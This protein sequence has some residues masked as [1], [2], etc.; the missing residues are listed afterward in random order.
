LLRLMFRGRSLP[1]LRPGWRFEPRSLGF[2]GRLGL[3]TSV[4]IVV[5][6]VAQSWILAQRDLEHIRGYLTER[7]RTI[8]EYLAQEATVGIL[9]GNVHGLR[10]LAEQARAQSGVV[11]CRMFDREGLVLVSVG[12]PPTGSVP[13][14]AKVGATGPIAIGTDVW[15]FRV[16]IL[17]RDAQ[18]QAESP[19]L[20]TVAIGLSAASLRELR[21]RTMTTASIFTSLFTL[22]AVGAALLLARAI[23]RPLQALATAADAI[24]RGDFGAQVDVRTGD[25][26]GGL[27]R[28]FNA[29]AQSLAR[30]RTTLEEY[31]GALEEKVLE[32]ERANHLKSEFLAT[33]SH[34]LRTPLNVIIGYVEMLAES[35]GGSLS[36][37]QQE[38]LGAI[39]R[40]SRLQLDLI[41]DILDF[42]RLSSG[43][44]S[45][46]VERFEL[47]PLLT[48]IRALYAA[49]LAS[50][51]VQL[52]VVVAADLPPLESD[53]IKLQEIVRN[54]VDNAIKFTEEGVVSVTGQAGETSG[55]LRIEVADT[56]AGMPPEDLEYIFDAFHQVGASSTRGTSGVGLGLSIVKQ[57]VEA[58]GGRV[59]VTSRVGQGSTFTIDIPHCLPTTRAAHADG[60]EGMREAAAALQEV[61]RNLTSAERTAPSSPPIAGRSREKA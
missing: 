57:L 9:T 36:P 5:I 53:R 22:L 30:S 18:L 32:L 26:L 2:A 29:M 37:D 25:E 40:Y 23:T 1:W 21:H 43:R 24:A 17:P 51:R 11:Y 6:C 10:Q 19:P 12:S 44:I 34:E 33:I 28:S 49:R 54:L 46:H 60:E 16:P 3:A 47:E 41:T 31:S 56:G 42:S 50:T 61:S 7:G 52:D 38:M 35:E 48:E 20:G 14:P 39:Q 15:E 13:P 55:W 58:L 59:S 4:L 8:G 45:F 27:A